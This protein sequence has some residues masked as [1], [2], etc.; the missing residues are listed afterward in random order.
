MAWAAIQSNLSALF[1]IGGTHLKISIII[2]LLVSL[3]LMVGGIYL[4]YPYFQARRRKSFEA[5]LH[6]TSCLMQRSFQGDIKHK[7]QEYM[8]HLIESLT[9]LKKSYKDLTIIL[10]D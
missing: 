6:Q 9:L 3:C 10:T 4:L 8:G 2:Y 5:E 7:R 1:G